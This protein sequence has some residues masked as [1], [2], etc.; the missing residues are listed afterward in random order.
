M[1]EAAGRNL[2]HPTHTAGVFG[3]R[4]KAIECAFVGKIFA[5]PFAD[6]E[7]KEVKRIEPPLEGKA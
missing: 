2:I 6:I 4:N 3:M 1:N 5:D 7:L